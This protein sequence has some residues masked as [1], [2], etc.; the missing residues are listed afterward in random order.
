M[1]LI[2]YVSFACMFG[3]TVNLSELRCHFDLVKFV[4][5]L[6]MQDIGYLLGMNYYVK[7][8]ILIQM[9]RMISWIAGNPHEICRG[10]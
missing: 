8:S 5:I 10:L 7:V 2:S 1:C 9:G 3:L 4:G 6:N